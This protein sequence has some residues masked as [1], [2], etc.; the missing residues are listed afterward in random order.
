MASAAVPLL[1]A[2]VVASA[3]SAFATIQQGRAASAEA[4]FQ[5]K[6]ADQNAQIASQNAAMELEAGEREATRLRQIRNRTIGAQA[7]AAGRSGLTLS[8]SVIDVMSDTALES[9]RDVANT[10]YAS[11]TGALNQNMAARDFANQ[12][13]LSRAAGKNA[14]TASYI[15]G[16]S[17]LIGGA[18]NAGLTYASIR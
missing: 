15:Q 18:A 10:L 11:R 13:K 6:V 14:R 3:G 17:T 8:G 4:K 7:A 9:E 12:S 5:A 16:G 2:S 1:I